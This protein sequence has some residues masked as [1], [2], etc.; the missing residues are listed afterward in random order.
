MA[1]AGAG[2]GGDEIPPGGGVGLASTGLSCEYHGISSLDDLNTALFRAEE[3][4]RKD[5]QVKWERANASA[6]RAALDQEKMKQHLEGVENLKEGERE[7]AE[8][9]AHLFHSTLT[10]QARRQHASAHLKWLAEFHSK[11]DTCIAHFL[12]EARSKFTE[13]A[14]ASEMMSISK[15]DFLASVDLD[16]F[17][18]PPPSSSSLPPILPTSGSF[19]TFNS[20][21]HNQTITPVKQKTE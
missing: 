10:P 1:R 12:P 13:L 2:A 7:D 17:S 21:S 20:S 8:V 14:I 4:T 9:I 15:S 11:L 18:S 19:V 16:N 6:E 3:K 5:E